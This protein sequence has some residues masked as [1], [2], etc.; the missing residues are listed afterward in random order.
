MTAAPLF[1]ALHHRGVLELSGED[2]FS[3]LQGLI[4]VNAESITEN[5]AVWTALLTPQGKV[6]H[7]FFIVAQGETLFLETE[8]SQMETLQTRLLRYKL[9]ARVKIEVCTDHNVFGHL[10]PLPRELSA[11]TNPGD[12]CLLPQAS[13][14]AFIDPRLSEGGARLIIHPTNATLYGPVTEDLSTW[15]RHRIHHGLPDGSQDIIP[16]KGFLL[17]YG[18]EELN[19]VDFK[20]GCYVGQETTARMK[21]KQ[22][23][24][25]RLLPVSIPARPTDIQP[26]ASIDGPDRSAGYLCSAA[27]DKTSTGILAL[28]ILNVRDLDRE[29]LQCNGYPVTVH[30]PHWLNLANSQT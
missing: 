26:L 7:D 20:K 5:H 23:V 10:F 8:R 25:K 3:F 28:A 24:K 30:R 1:F 17:E 18:F 19:G 27:P 2:R 15:E 22:L 14:I 6:L 12:T 13:G 11:L 4:S 9:R 29:D 16:E 21:W